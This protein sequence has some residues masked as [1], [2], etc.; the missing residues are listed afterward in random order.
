MNK[1]EEFFC[2]NVLISGWK[3]IF[4]VLDSSFI[5]EGYITSQYNQKKLPPLNKCGNVDETKIEKRDGLV[6]LRG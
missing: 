6:M 5:K 2:L 1:T 4:F 3:S